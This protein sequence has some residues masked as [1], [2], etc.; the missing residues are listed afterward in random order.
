LPRKGSGF[1]FLE[2]DVDS[3]RNLHDDFVSKTKTGWPR[4][5]GAAA[6]ENSGARLR[7]NGD[8][9]VESFLERK[10]VTPAEAI[11]T[12]QHGDRSQELSRELSGVPVGTDNRARSP[13]R[14]LF[15]CA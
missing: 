8:H 5:K 11:A 6:K 3:E 14:R 13:E 2:F 7:Q 10:L 12:V 4:R 9:P 1:L 15:C